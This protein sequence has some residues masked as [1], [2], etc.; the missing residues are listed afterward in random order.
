MT[1]NRH[2]VHSEKP[3]KTSGLSFEDDTTEI[4]ETSA[5]FVGD[6]AYEQKHYKQVR[7]SPKVLYRTVASGDIKT[8]NSFEKVS[9]RKN[10]AVAASQGEA[11]LENMARAMNTFGEA[12]NSRRSDPEPDLVNHTPFG[13]FV[14]LDT[15]HRSDDDEDDD[16]DSQAGHSCTSIDVPQNSNRYTLPP[17]TPGG[18]I[19]ELSMAP[20][21]VTS[22]S[23]SPPQHESTKE[24]TELETKKTVEPKI[25]TMQV[26]SG[27]SDVPLESKEIA[28]DPEGEKISDDSAVDDFEEEEVLSQETEYEE[29]ELIEEEDV[30][31]EEEADEEMV[32]DEKT[33]VTVQ[34]EGIVEEVIAGEETVKTNQTGTKLSGGNLRNFWEKKTKKD[35]DLKDFWEQKA[36]KAQQKK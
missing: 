36:Q 3:S 2:T 11:S 24:Q 14:A 1:E 18:F 34:E 8:R 6:A 23:V 5:H 28:R 13:K 21:S 33:Q 35:Q 4:S 26:Q 30:I 9:L 25:D 27:F 19:S 16:D 29:E 15:G 7:M 20:S 22:M 32:N 17:N 31:E 12:L 10:A